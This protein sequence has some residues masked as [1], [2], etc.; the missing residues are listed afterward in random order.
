MKESAI[1]RPFRAS[2]TRLE[3]ASGEIYIRVY[4][5]DVQLKYNDVPEP[6]PIPRS[7]VSMTAKACRN[8]SHRPQIHCV[9]E[10]EVEKVDE[11]VR[12]FL[13]Y[14]LLASD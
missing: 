8:V 13:L 14:S 2:E 6:S 3:S 11:F 7:G 1:K 10:E 5:R 12:Y 4:S 9:E